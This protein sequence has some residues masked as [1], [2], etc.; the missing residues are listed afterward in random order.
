MLLAVGGCASAVPVRTDVVDV[1]M[2]AQDRGWRASYLVDDSERGSIEVP[3]GR[4][5]HVPLGAAVHLTLASDEYVSIFTVPDL[6]LRRFAAP[7]RPSTLTFF[8]DRVGRYEVRGDEMC[9]LPHTDRARG[10]L[11]VEPADAFQAWMRRQI[12]EVHS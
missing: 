10:W 7:R 1:H 9:G 8:A 3:T 2:V 6:D 12:R 11:V 4:E 5:V